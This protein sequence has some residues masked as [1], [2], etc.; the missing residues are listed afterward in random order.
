MQCTPDS[1]PCISRQLCSSK[2][3]KILKKDRINFMKNGYSLIEVLVAMA[4]FAITSL[5]LAAGVG[6]VIRAG[7]VSER[8]TQATI[9]AQEKLEEFRAAFEPLRNGEDTPR[10]GYVRRW[11]VTSDSP[12]VG[13]ARVDVTVSWSADAARAVALVT[14]VNQ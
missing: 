6:A 5:G 3:Y 11:Q 8:V 13:V 1:L 9:L 2:K 12:E 4:I 14:V 7:Q 10:A